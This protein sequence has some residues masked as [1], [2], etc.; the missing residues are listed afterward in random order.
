MADIRKAT[1]YAEWLTQNQD[2]RGT[3]QYDTVRRAYLETRPSTGMEKTA[4]VGKGINVGLADVLGAPVDLINQ[5]PRVLNIL[6]GEQ[7]FEP[8][9]EQ[10][11]GGSKSLRKLTSLLDIGYDDIQD[12]PSSQRPFA[13]GGETFGQTTGTVLPFMAAS[14]GVSA[15]DAINTAIPKRNVLT[16]TVSD[17]VKTQARNPALA[18]SIE[19]G[20]ALAPSAAAGIAEQVDPSDATTRLYA[21]LGAAFTPVVIANS[22]PTFYNSVV[23][24]IETFRPRGVERQ[25]AEVVQR[26]VLE[27]G[28]EPT[29]LAQELRASSDAGTSGQITGSKPLLEIEKELINSSSAFREEVGEQTQR[30]IEE[31]NQAFRTATATGDPDVVRT[32]AQARQDFLNT[33]LTTRVKE[34]ELRAQNIERSTLPNVDKMAVNKQARDILEKELSIARKTERELWTEIDQKAPVEAKKTLEIQK[35]IIENDLPPGG[36]LPQPVRALVKQIKKGDVNKDLEKGQTIAGDLIKTRSIYNKLRTEA[37]ANKKFNDARIYKRMTDAMLDDLD[38]VVGKE[39]QIARQFSKDLN[40]KFT[41]GYVGKTL[42]YDRDG[43]ISVAPERT[44]E[45]ALSGSDV[46]QSLNLGALQRAAGSQADQMT[47]LQSQFIKRLASETANFD[48]SINPQTLETFIKNNRQTLQSLNLEKELSDVASANRF[49]NRV[50]EVAQK[51]SAFAAK[52]STAAK[53][54]NSNNVNDVIKTAIASPTRKQSIDNL[55]ILVNRAKQP[56]AFEG[57]QYGIYQYLLDAA[58]TSGGLVSGRR[59]NQLL[60]IRSGNE[61][62]EQT[63]RRTGIFKEPQINNIKRLITK[64]TQFEDS[65][66]NTARASDLLGGEDLFFD[67]LLRIGGANLGGASGLAQAAGAPLVLA[68][69]GV[70]T[71]KKI[72]EQVPKLKVRNVLA[73]AIKNPKLM[74]TLLEKPTTLVARKARLRRLNAILIQAGI[75]DGSEILEEEN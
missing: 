66:A 56:E 23:R 29:L 14:R 75:F 38:V 28:Q 51:G 1:K 63:L 73:E 12:L 39:A 53:V 27:A 44:L 33:A 65:L 15:V 31:L 45:T 30:A 49:A 6:P 20:L 54:L 40:D 34:A 17:L 32:A 25:A 4:A 46:Q 11:I 62:L 16:E 21:E 71:A 60:Q 22:I 2:K 24:A 19:G 41:K 7:G 72:F 36:K 68:G 64:S 3:D 52:K 10:P 59:L 48:G 74:A 8:F 26:Q 9:S 35:D 47:D 69:A 50:K 42:G 57:L 70:R 55:V 13:V 58:T 18:A 37:L 67:L 61:T 43:S 5:L